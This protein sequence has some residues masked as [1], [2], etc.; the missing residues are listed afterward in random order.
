MKSDFYPFFTTVATVPIAVG[1]VLDPSP[2]RF[3]FVKYSEDASNWEFKHKFVFHVPKF[4]DSNDHGMKK[5]SVGEYWSSCRANNSHRF[6][7]MDWDVTSWPYKGWLEKFNF[8]GYSTR[9]PGTMP[10]AVGAAYKPH[11]FTIFPG[12]ENASRDGWSHQFV[13]WAYPMKPSN[14]RP[15]NY[16]ISQF[17]QLLHFPVY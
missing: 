3:M 12:S 14:T 6:R 9:K 1:D 15:G 11:R 7:I 10:Y 5:Y 4:F 16:T 17:C 13:F 8:F 2:H